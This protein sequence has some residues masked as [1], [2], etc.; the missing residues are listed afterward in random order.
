MNHLVKNIIMIGVILLGTSCGKFLDRPVQDVLTDETIGD[1]LSND[2]SQV[3]SFL[4]IGYRTLC[5]SSLYGRQ[6]YHA[7]PEMAHEVDLDY[8]ADL[9]WN[10]F[11]KNDMTSSN[12]YATNIYTQFYVVIAN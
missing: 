8:I 4:A 2:P 7:L 10:E 11:S 9:G 1:V 6:L 3:S 5:N 12:S